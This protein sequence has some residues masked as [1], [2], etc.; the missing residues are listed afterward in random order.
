MKSNPDRRVGVMKRIITIGSSKPIHKITIRTKKLIPL[1]AK[2]ILSLLYSESE[3]C[4]QMINNK[5]ELSI[6]I[7]FII[8]NERKEKNTT[9]VMIVVSVAIKI[10]NNIVFLIKKPCSSFITTLNKNEG[11]IMHINSI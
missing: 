7:N 4:Q 6:N 3:K 8:T 5:F 2:S 11:K 1:N 9:K 10:K